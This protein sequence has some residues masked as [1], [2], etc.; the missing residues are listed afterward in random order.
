MQAEDSRPPRITDAERDDE[1]RGHLRIPPKMSPSVFGK[2]ENRKP[3]PAMAVRTETAAVAR[4][5][6]ERERAPATAA[7]GFGS[8]V[9]GRAW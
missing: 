1:G 3:S 8:R 4:Q 6:K 7:M 5:E 9:E 2:A